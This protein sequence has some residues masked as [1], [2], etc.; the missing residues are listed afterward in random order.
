MQLRSTRVASY[1]F[2]NMDKD[3]IKSEEI[4]TYLEDNVEEQ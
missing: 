2:V 4:Q 3:C 1:V